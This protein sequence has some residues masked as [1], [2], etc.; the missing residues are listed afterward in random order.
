MNGGE[1]LRIRP[2]Q[3]ADWPSVWALLEPV[4]RKGDTYVFDPAISETEARAVWVEAPL[5]TFVAEQDGEIVG[6]CYLKPNQPGAGSHVCNCG[7]VVAARAAGRGIA[8]QMCVHSQEQAVGHG[9]LAMQFNFVVSTNAAAVRLW[10]KLGFEIVGTLPAAFRHPGLGRVDA[11][12]MH[13]FLA[14]GQDADPR[15]G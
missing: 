8:S 13:K 10:R 6:T 14:D 5:A 12:V 15:E 4:F 3:A 1:A 11:Y 7:Y 2:Y 9:F